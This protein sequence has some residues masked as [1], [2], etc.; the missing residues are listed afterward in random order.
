[1]PKPNE[2]VKLLLTNNTIQSKHPNCTI[3][4]GETQMEIRAWAY[5]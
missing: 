4:H 2:Y 1:M 3:L 5:V